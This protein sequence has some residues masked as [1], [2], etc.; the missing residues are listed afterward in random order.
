MPTKV[1]LCPVMSLLV[2]AGVFMGS[3]ELHKEPVRGCTVQWSRF[4]CVSEEQR[5]M[6]LA[7]SEHMNKKLNHGPVNQ[8][9]AYDLV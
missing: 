7:V 1:S 6:H 5:Y 3:P 9:I 4:V 2:A 8:F